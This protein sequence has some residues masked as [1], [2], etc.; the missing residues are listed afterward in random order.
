MQQVCAA[1]PP[2]ALKDR[3][4]IPFPAANI[5]QPAPGER[6]HDRDRL[7]PDARQRIVAADGAVLNCSDPETVRD[8]LEQAFGPFPVDLSLDN[9]DMLDHAGSTHPTEGAFRELLAALDSHRSV[10]VIAA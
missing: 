6:Q 9:R 5:G 2:V 10:R 3:D 1:A 7:P 4:R 8:A